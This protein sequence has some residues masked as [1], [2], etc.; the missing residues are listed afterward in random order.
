MKRSTPSNIHVPPDASQQFSPRRNP[1]D[2]PL[3]PLSG[4]A[5]VSLPAELDKLENTAET[6]AERGRSGELDG[7]EK[8][9]A[10]GG[11]G[12][13]DADNLSGEDASPS[14]HGTLTKDNEK[15]AKKEKERRTDNA[16][17]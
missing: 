15:G 1:I 5:V 10:V 3:L 11:V 17:M 13:V 14:V 2:V 4:R 12:G 9:T 6:D 16:H 7:V 8:A